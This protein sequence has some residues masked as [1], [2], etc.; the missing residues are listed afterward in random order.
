MKMPSFSRQSGTTANQS[1]ATANPSGTT[2]N[3]SGTTAND[4]RPTLVDGTAVPAQDRAD[5]SAVPMR[6]RDDD[7]TVTDRSLGAHAAT[8]TP[9]DRTAADRMSADRNGA[10]RTFTNRT[11]TDRIDADPT[12]TD[13]TLADR[14][15][16][17]RTLA[18]RTQADRTAAERA[19]ASARVE[20]TD[21]E[22]A[23]DRATAERTATQ[24]TAT[25]RAA[26]QRTTAHH[27]ATDADREPDRTPTVTGPKPRASLLATLG[28][29]TGVVSA[30]LVLSGPLAGYG[31]GLAVLGLLLSFGG[32]RAT[33]RRH[34]AGKSDAL[35]G[36]L[37]SLGAIVVGM[38][39]LT[40]SLPW[41]GTDMDS[42]SRL[43]DWLD[44]RFANLF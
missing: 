16:A 30:L 14:T 20:R 42:A 9:A 37:V 44:A 7:T 31:V 21:A 25:Q 1:G 43:R 26:T 18:D 24:G 3:Q 41:L 15:Q 4:E 27:S 40:G 36:L 8:T 22:R 34:V 23:A 10:D 11:G 38:L 35:I 29:I 2:A 13:R 32:M 17:D 12:L 6:T 33:R 19:E 28:L 39:A 5:A